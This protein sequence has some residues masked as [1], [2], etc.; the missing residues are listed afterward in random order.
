M[1]KRHGR[2]SLMR[3]ILDL[4]VT[5][6]RRNAAAVLKILSASKGPLAITQ[7][8]RAVAVM[9]SIGAHERGE[10][11]RRVLELLARGEREIA[12][13]QGCDLRAV[14]VEVDAFL[15]EGESAGGRFLRTSR[16][17]RSGRRRSESSPS[18]G[19]A[20]IVV[21]LASSG[22][23]VAWSVNRPVTAE[24]PSGAMPIPKA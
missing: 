1:S 15:A 19:T 7:R 14:L 17:R 23:K 4:T 22:P 20:V 5:D 18:P 6:P 10:H 3:E 16:R 24:E 13:R 11:E 21:S 9:L 12:R 2:H 8:G